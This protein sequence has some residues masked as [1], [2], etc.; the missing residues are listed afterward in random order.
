MA[1]EIRY[2][3]QSLSPGTLTMENERTYKGSGQAA[4]G[5]SHAGILRADY[6]LANGSLSSKHPDEP[7]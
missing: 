6:V 1:S 3:G 2:S 7:L 5:I 4:D